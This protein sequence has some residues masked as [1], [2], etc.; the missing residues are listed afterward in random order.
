MGGME[1]LVRRRSDGAR[2][3]RKAFGMG[4]WTCYG[5]PLFLGG[6]YVSEVVGLVEPTLTPAPL[7]R[8]V[9]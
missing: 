9:R 7:G 8:R 5:I 3:V 4:F 1:G 2:R 6:D